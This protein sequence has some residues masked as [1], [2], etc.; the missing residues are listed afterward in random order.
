MIDFF[1]RSNWGRVV[2]EDWRFLAFCASQKGENGKK[3]TDPKKKNHRQEK[4]KKRAKFLLKKSFKSPTK[5]RSTIL[6]HTSLRIKNNGRELCKDGSAFRRRRGGR[7]RRVVAPSTGGESGNDGTYLKKKRESVR[8][9]DFFWSSLVSSAL[10]SSSALSR[11]F[12][13]SRFLRRF[14]VPLLLALSSEGGV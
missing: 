5:F 2:R 8:E 6:L 14:S 7:R 11:C 13:V 10:K 4:A 1:I 3:R 9:L 12:Y